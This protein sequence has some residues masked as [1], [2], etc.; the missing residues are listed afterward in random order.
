MLDVY[1]LTI[2]SPR[3][4]K[5]APSLIFSSVGLYC[6]DVFQSRRNSLKLSKSGQKQ[7][8][9]TGDPTLVAKVA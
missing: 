4:N 8:Q 9:T 3:N 2:I 5:L 1:M 7:S 6:C